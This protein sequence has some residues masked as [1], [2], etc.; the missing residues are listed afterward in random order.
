MKKFFELKTGC[1]RWWILYSRFFGC[2]TRGNTVTANQIHGF[3]FM[4]GEMVFTI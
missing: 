4:Q 3:Y 1:A 2:P